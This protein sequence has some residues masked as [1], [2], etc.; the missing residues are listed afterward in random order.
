MNRQGWLVPAAAVPLAAA[1][2]ALVGSSGTP[3]ASAPPSGVDRITLHCG[4]HI[5]DAHG[6]YSY[7]VALGVTRPDGHT[8]KRWF[9]DPPPVITDPGG[10]RDNLTL[11]MR[12]AQYGTYTVTLVVTTTDGSE[13]TAMACRATLPRRRDTTLP[14]VATVGNWREQAA[15]TLTYFPD[16]TL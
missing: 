5:P 13:P 8:I 15:T 9:R 2:L 1:A 4:L 14:V 11:T 10:Y 12:R 3:R 16:G 6:D 7:R